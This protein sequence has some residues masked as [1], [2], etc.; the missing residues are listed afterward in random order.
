MW[1]VKTKRWSA[2]GLIF[3]GVV[4]GII[5]ASNFNWTPKGLAKR[6]AGDEF[7]ENQDQ[8]SAAV[9]RLQDTGG[10]YIHIKND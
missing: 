8:P 3:I 1:S 6:P 7:I 9:L 2:A 4:A 5:F 10:Q